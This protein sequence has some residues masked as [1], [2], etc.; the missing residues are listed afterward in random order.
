MEQATT[1]FRIDPHRFLR[2]PQAIAQKNPTLHP[3][4]YALHLQ[5]RQKM[6]PGI[7]MKILRD[8]AK[9]S[10]S[11]EP[12]LLGGELIQGIGR[13]VTY[14]CPYNGPI[15]GALT[16]TNYKLYFKSSERE[17]LF[18]LDV[19]LGLI[20]KI[21]KIGG[22]TSRGENS[23]GIDLIC[24]SKIKFAILLLLLDNSSFKAAFGGSSFMC[25]EDK[26]DL[27]ILQ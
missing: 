15:K 25:V 7:E 19:P 20:S 13:D 4:P 14:L 18:I 6:Y 5:R 1:Q 3:N 17:S 26:Q 27:V 11:D 22:A 8:S 2:K 16:V 23:Y 10:Q 21:E 9:V 12:P 24:K